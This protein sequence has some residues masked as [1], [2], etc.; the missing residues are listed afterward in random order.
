M[1]WSCLNLFNS[2][3]PF[4]HFFYASKSTPS[5]TCSHKQGRPQ[6]ETFPPDW[7]HRF[8]NSPVTHS[9]GTGTQVRFSTSLLWEYR[10]QQNPADW[11]RFSS[12]LLLPQLLRENIK[13]KNTL[14]R[15]IDKN[16]FFF[17]EQI[18]LLSILNK[19]PGHWGSFCLPWYQHSETRQEHPET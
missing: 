7:N 13:D 14:K 9:A 3:S 6:F 19:V 16:F 15:E 4:L 17:L 8:P 10:L 1:S 12:A 18:F 2:S 5:L 11:H